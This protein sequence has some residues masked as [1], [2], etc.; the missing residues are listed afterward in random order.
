MSRPGSLPEG[1][2]LLS[3]YCK[4]GRLLADRTGCAN[5]S[6]VKY[7]LSTVSS[8][9]CL[10][11]EQVV[12]TVFCQ[13]LPIYCK[14]G[15]L[16]VDRTGCPNQSSVSYCLSTVSRKDCLRTK[17]VVLT[18]AVP[19]C[20]KQ[21]GLFVDLTGYKQGTGYPNQSCASLS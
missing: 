17:Q 16:F 18:R 4:Q 11:T 12:Q 14:Q 8:K 3:F 15:R 10:R 5:Q 21:G 6:S 7:C 9:D 19:F 1:C 20:R 2:Q 13:L